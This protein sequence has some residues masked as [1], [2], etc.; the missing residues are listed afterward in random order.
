MNNYGV[1][2][3]LD[4]AL[5]KSKDLYWSVNLNGSHYRSVIQSV[6]AG[7]GSGEDN[8]WEAYNGTFLRGEG[9]DYYNMYYYKYCGVDQKSGLALYQATVS[10]TDLQNAANNPNDSRFDAIRGHQVGDIIQTV[11]YEIAD[12]Y[13]MGTATPDLIGGFGTTLQYKGFDLT[14]LFSFQLGG[15]YLS[16]DYAYNL[17]NGS[18]GQLG[19]ALSKDLQGN[20]WTPEN[21]GARF[22]MQMYSNDPYTTGSTLGSWKYS[23]MGLFSA[24]YLNM[25]NLT[26]GYTLPASLLNR[27]GYVSNLRV[28]A[29][30]DN[31]YTLTAKK[32]VEPRMS[33]T[34]GADVGASPYPYMRSMSLGID[35]S[36]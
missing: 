33:L 7:V 21:T 11:N 12:R 20:T 26:A 13:E 32:G 9:K 15:L 24:S 2:A 14:A 17:Y 8:T 18:A 19:V 29:T 31:F 30:L 25:K 1:E 36:F 22:P 10:E 23:D 4:V 16:N 3:S 28:F 5:I 35:I 27:I 34:G 6:P